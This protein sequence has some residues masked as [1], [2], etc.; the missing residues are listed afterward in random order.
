MSFYTGGKKRKIK[1][2]SP[3]KRK[4][5]S[6]SRRRKPRSSSITGDLNKL[7]QEVG[8]NLNFGNKRSL[9]TDMNSAMHRDQNQNQNQNLLAYQK[10]FPLNKDSNR[11][12][13]N[14]YPYLKESPEL[15]PEDYLNQNVNAEQAAYLGELIRKTQ[16][17]MEG[18]PQAMEYVEKWDDN[19]P[20]RTYPPTQ[21]QK[22][23]FSNQG[24][25][26]L[27]ITYPNPFQNKNEDRF[28][29]ESQ[30]R[31][32][33]GYTVDSTK[34][35]NEDVARNSYLQ[36]DAYSNKNKSDVIDGEKQQLF[37]EGPPLQ[38]SNDD[39]NFYGTDVLGVQSFHG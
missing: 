33:T 18:S 23:G 1:S 39:S 35:G 9:V 22:G 8:L 10:Y 11:Y 24:S 6:P 26:S 16:K 12:K 20:D 27:P 5:R 32:R 21:L 15:S 4:S 7:G 38:R 34:E 28:L 2:R 19:N 37:V 3:S 25:Y 17:T 36:V 30:I 13:S 14:E 31:K 29:T